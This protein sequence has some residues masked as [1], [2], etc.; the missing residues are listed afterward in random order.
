MAKA[1]RAWRS[2]RRTDL[3]GNN[4]KENQ[5][6][7]ELSVLWAFHVNFNTVLRAVKGEGLVPTYIHADDAAKARQ[8]I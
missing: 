1:G 4:M 5:A 7:L 2:Q 3:D 6:Q 8:P